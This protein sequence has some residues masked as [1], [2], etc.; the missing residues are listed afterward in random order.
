MVGQIRKPSGLQLDFT[1]RPPFTLPPQLQSDHSQCP[2]PPG[3]V[4][5]EEDVGQTLRGWVLSAFASQDF[6]TDSAFGLLPNAQTSGT[7]AKVRAHE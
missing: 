1:L 5:V 3:K 7:V 2:K 4:K 6:L